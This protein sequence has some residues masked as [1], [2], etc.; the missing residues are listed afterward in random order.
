METEFNDLRKLVSER[1]VRL[2]EA[3]Q[4][5]GFIHECDDVQD[6]MRDQTVKA[7][8][9]EYGNDLE[10]VE[11]LIQAFDTFHVSL[12]NSE[13]RVVQCIENGNVLI[14]SKTS[15]SSEVQQKVSELRA[16]WDD[17][18]ELVNARKEALNGAKQV[19]LFDRTAEEIISWIHEK[20]SDLIYGA[21]LQ[22]SEAI[23]K[24]IR[25]H[26]ALETEMKAIKERVEYIIQEGDR[27]VSEYPDTKEHID[28]RKDDTLSAW[29]DLLIKV[30][31]ER[32]Y[33][34]QSEQLQSYFD[35]YQ[36]L[37]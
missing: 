28:D 22:D 26:Q 4:Y 36:E 20:E 15:Y 13:P 7:D 32:D 5:F 16:S 24:L 9:E 23:E 2:A 19:H 3:L 37:L 21:Y 11:L 30:E 14:N 25:K 12:L 35:E 34:L 17:L 10:H 8:S 1:E 33:L 29:E 27:L 6:W 18:I 31:R